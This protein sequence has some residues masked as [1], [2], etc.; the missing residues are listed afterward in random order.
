MRYDVV[1]YMESLKMKT[2]NPSK[3]NIKSSI[4]TTV[5]RTIYIHILKHV[6][7]HFVDEPIS[8]TKKPQVEMDQFLKKT[9]PHAYSTG[10]MNVL[11]VILL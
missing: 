9:I 8:E 3:P 10:D 5:P 6:V 1:Q 7:N 2:K 4:P 11:L